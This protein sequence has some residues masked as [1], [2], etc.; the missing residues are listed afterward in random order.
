[1]TDIGIANTKS[2]LSHICFPVQQQLS[3]TDHRLL[4]EE[5]A[6]SDTKDL[7]EASLQ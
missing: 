1:M 5:L 7:L 3:N 6:N 2:G 4:Y